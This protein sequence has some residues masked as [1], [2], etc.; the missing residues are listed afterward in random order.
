MFSSYGSPDKHATWSTPE[1][2]TVSSE[3]PSRLGGAV[4]GWGREKA[5]RPNFSKEQT[6]TA[7]R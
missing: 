4:S 3:L 2:E 7:F 6:L 1:V 5:E